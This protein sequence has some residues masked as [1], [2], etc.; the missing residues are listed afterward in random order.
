MLCRGGGGQV[1]EGLDISDNNG[2][3]VIITGLPFSP[4]MDPKVVLKMKFLDDILKQSGK[5]PAM[6]VC[7]HII[8]T[9]LG[10]FCFNLECV[11]HCH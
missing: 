7:V 5:V 10:V 4:V 8:L 3:A 1:S 9:P 6:D 2:R 11:T